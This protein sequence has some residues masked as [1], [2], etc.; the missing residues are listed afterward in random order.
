M[1]TIPK[2]KLEYVE[3]IVKLAMNGTIEIH[4]LFRK[5]EEIFGKNIGQGSSRTVYKFDDNDVIK[6]AVGIIGIKRENAKA[7]FIEGIAQNKTEVNSSTCASPEYITKVINHASN[8]S[9]IIQEYARPITEIEFEDITGVNWN[10]FEETLYYYFYD[11]PVVSRKELNDKAKEDGVLAELLKNSW[12][13]GFF[14]SVINCKWVPGD[15]IEI[16]H[17]GKIGNRVVLVDYGFN[18]KVMKQHYMDESIEE[19]TENSFDVYKTI[20]KSDPGLFNALARQARLVIEI[21]NKN[22]DYE[23]GKELF[24]ILNQ[25][26]DQNL[27]SRIKEK[28]VFAFIDAALTKDSAREK[29]KKLFFKLN[30]KV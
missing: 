20:N 2:N 5:L 9:W 30:N 4:K 11:E 3:Y 15:L 13:S 1:T 25:K 24:G 8:F 28:D 21:N 23:K 7:S 22:F 18:E 6:I 14:D 19:N 12:F 10:Y 27:I 26:E 16:Q 17:Y 29:V